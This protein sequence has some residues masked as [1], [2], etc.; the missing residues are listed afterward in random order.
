MP[1]NVKPILYWSGLILISIFSI[2]Y[3]VY[4]LFW[5]EAPLKKDKLILSA[6]GFQD[7]AGWRDDDLTA[8]LPSMMRSCDK[9]LTLPDNRSL[10]ADNLAGVASDWKELCRQA[11]TLPKATEDIRQFFEANFTP[12]ALGNNQEKHGLFTGYYEASLNGHTQKTARYKYP[13]HLR[14]QEL[15]MVDLGRFRADLKGRRIA[16]KVIDGKLIPFANRRAID[17][18]ALDNRALELVWVDSE[19]DAFFLQIQ[20]SGIVEMADG[21]LLRIGYAGQNGHP[22]FAIGKELISNGSISREKMSMQ[23]IRNWL[24][25]NPDKNR[26]IMHLNKSYVFFRELNG[27][28]PL[29]A[30]NVALTPERSLA[31]DRKWIPLGVPV[32]LAAAVPAENPAH[33]DL[34]FAKLMMAQDTGGAIRGPVR[35]D[36]FWGHGKR[37]YEIAG[38]MKAEGQVWMLLPNSVAAAALNK[39]SR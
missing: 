26:E 13:L 9:L 36:V 4:L 15:V 11:Q 22:Y 10:G 3:I 39:N 7:L 23:A 8:F 28:G 6:V 19:I 21:S 20:G 17:K 31:V 1:A 18:G 25:Q 34:P 33:E 14:P 29:G 37:A 35:G 2:G 12:L 30:Q 16:G 24:E 32:W 27:A 5:F 38:R